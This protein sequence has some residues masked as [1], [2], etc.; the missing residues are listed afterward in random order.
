MVIFI[1]T[2]KIF[3]GSE[4]FLIIGFRMPEPIEDSPL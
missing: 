2:M 4:E 1:S 3:A